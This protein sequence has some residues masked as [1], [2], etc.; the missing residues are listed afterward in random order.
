M[1]KTFKTNKNGKIE[2]TKRELE[3]LLD[4][5]WR[6]GYNSNNTYTWSSPYW[7]PTTTTYPYNPITWTYLSDGT[8]NC[9][10]KEVD[11]I[12]TNTCSADY[13]NKNLKGI[14]INVGE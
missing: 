14:T 13:Q 5:I 9:E 11:S 4:E 7:W 1:T 10:T 2:F 6:D 12:T 8:I 3:K